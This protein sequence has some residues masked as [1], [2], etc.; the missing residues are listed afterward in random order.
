MPKAREGALADKRKK[1]LS[2]RRAVWLEADPKHRKL[3]DFIREAHGILKT[4]KTRKFQRLDGQYVK[5]LRYEPIRGGGCFLHLVAETPGDHAS[6]LAMADED[7][8]GSD[9]ATAPPPQGSEFMDGD[10]FALVK[11]ND[12][13]LCASA[14]RDAAIAL[15]CQELF[16]KSRRDA[17]ATQFDLQKIA[18]VDKMKIIQAEGVKEIEIRATLYA[19]TTD[20][21]KRKTE[22]AGAIGAVGKHLKAVFWPEGQVQKD[23]L[24][25]GITLRADGRMKAGKALGAK[26]LKTIAEDVVGDDDDYVI[27]TKKGQRISRSEVYVRQRVDIERHGKSVKRDAAWDALTAFHAQLAS[28]GVIG[29]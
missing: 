17:V 10:L 15:Y 9:V 23:N 1:T 26:R 25:V 5:C 6:T 21:L 22:A 20:Y 7:K 4:V 19:A 16:R 28:S 27:H 24:Q 3:E 29:Q 12:V 14:L 13:C 2:Y 11:G 8:E 18:D